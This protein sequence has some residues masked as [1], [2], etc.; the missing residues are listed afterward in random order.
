M[1][2]YREILS[3][4]GA[5]AFCLSGLLARSGGA[6]MSIGIVLM[7]RGI[8]GSYELAGAVAA[9]QSLAWAIGTAV[10]S[11]LVDRKGQRRVMLPAVTCFATALSVM[12]ILA[13][14]QVWWG[15]LFIP[16][17]IGGF[18]GGSPGALVRARWNHAIKDTHLLHTALSLESTLDEFTWVVG[19]VA[20]AALCTM[21]V[22]EAGLAAVIVL[23]IS[24][25]LVFYSLRE[26]E[27][28]VAPPEVAEGHQ[29]FLLRIPGAAW[30]IAVSGTIGFLF[31]ASDLTVVAAVEIWGS[32]ELSGVVLGT[33]A[34]GSALS[35]FAYGSRRWATPL[36]RRWL[37]GAFGMLLGT[38]SLA[39][40]WSPLSLAIAGFV[41]GFAIAPTLINLNAVMQRL[42]PESR[43][44][45]ALA[46]I[47]TAI[48]IGASMGSSL[49]GWLI[50]NVDF[51]AGFVAAAIAAVVA[52]ALTVLSVARLSALI[53]RKA[54]PEPAS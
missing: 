15:W 19:P 52:T 43:L 1:R 44:T 47:G 9:V 54:T 26:T 2:A 34:V 37:I 10:L 53:T 22:P 42:V 4:P 36:H 27:P 40:T 18:C 11:N 30:I 31:G 23:T 7:I 6:M 46:W 48:G 12:I 28:P 29:E 5:L 25:S 3:L 13:A 41:A 16:C 51:R 49:G 35:G 39:F 24:G 45:E 32:P 38:T 50:D 21:L 8:Y 17:A 20:A 14:L 33:I